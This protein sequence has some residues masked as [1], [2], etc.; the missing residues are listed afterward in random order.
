MPEHVNQKVSERIDRAAAKNPWNSHL[1]YYKTLSGRLE[2]FDLRQLQDTIASK[3][4]WPLFAPTFLNKETLVGKFGQ[5]AELRNALSHSRSADEV[6]R[7]EGEAAILWF[8]QVVVS[9]K[10][11]ITADHG[12]SSLCRAVSR[13]ASRPSP[14]GWTPPN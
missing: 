13:G 10:L 7:K 4:L 1:D 6:T 5:L 2:Y 11:P 3:A 14:G 8:G 9:E 12:S